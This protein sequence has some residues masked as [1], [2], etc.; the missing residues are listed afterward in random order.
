MAHGRDSAYTNIDADDGFTGSKLQNIVERRFRFERVGYSYRATELEAAI[1]LSELERWT[2][3]LQKRRENAARLTELLSN[4]PA[5]QTQKTPPGFE[6]AHMMFPAVVRKG[7]DRDKLLMFMEERGIETRYLFP[8]LSQPVY[9]NLFPGLDNKYPV[10]QRLA[11][12]GFMIGIHQGLT[13]EDIDYI[14]DVVH[15]GLR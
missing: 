2:E 7:M 5:I 4:L 12:D 6:H 15:E 3:N 11:Q 9:Q 14:S 8:L 1:A 10:A 13:F